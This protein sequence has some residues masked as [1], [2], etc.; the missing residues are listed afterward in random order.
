MQNKTIMVLAIVSVL[1]GGTILS[2]DAQV[3]GDVEIDI[4]PGS[5]PNS[6]NPNSNGVIPMLLVGTDDFD[7]TDVDVDTLAFGPDG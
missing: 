7:V 6:I 4:K 1:I 2:V 3:R 5:D